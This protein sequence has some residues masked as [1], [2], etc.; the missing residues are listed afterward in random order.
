[1]HIMMFIVIYIVARQMMKIMTLEKYADY[2]SD[3]G[4]ENDAD[5]DVENDAEY[6]VENLAYH[7]VENEAY[8]GV[9]HDA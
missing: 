7:S 3:C 9:E 5:Y 6:G 4:V 8:Y 1:M 2:E